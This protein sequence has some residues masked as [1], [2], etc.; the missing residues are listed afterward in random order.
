MSDVV[1]VCVCLVYFV[2]SPFV[3]TEERKTRQRHQFVIAVIRLCFFIHGLTEFLSLHSSISAA[4]HLSLFTP[5]LLLFVVYAFP[6]YLRCTPFCLFAPFPCP[7]SLSYLTSLSFSV[8]IFYTF[9]L[10]PL[11]IFPFLFHFFLLLT[12]FIKVFISAFVLFLYWG[13]LFYLL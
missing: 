3:C 10:P 4:A 1:C 2:I 7:S 5:L 11:H 8:Y 9:F 13:E 12:A 6:C